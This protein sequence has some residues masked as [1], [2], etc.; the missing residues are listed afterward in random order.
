MRRRAARNSGES[1]T[2]EPDS[3]RHATATT[4]PLH[5]IGGTAIFHW[6]S[7]EARINKVSNHIA[8]PAVVASN[9]KRIAEAVSEAPDIDTGRVRA[10]RDALAR[11]VYEVNTER[12]AEKLIEIDT[13]SRGNGRFRH[14]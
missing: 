1:G 11:G 10:A 2:P 13:A 6:Q 12:I 14:G 8:V 9:L 5:D 7:N 4:G 3:A